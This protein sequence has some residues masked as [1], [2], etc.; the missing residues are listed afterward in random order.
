MTENDL[1]AY[2]DG[3]LD[4]GRRAEAEAWLAEHPEDAE[5][6]AAW[7]RFSQQLNDRFD[8]VL[9]EPAPLHL[10][11]AARGRPPVRPQVSWR[12]AASFAG[13]TL[14]AGALG[15]VIGYQA[16]GNAPVVVAAQPPSFAQRAMVAHAV[17]AP[18]QRRA[19]E[20]DAEHE[21]QLVRWL[22][23]RL[24][25]PLRVP[26]LQPLGYALEGGR[27]LPG[28]QGPVA[29]FMYRDGAGGRLTLYVSNEAPG[30]A[31]TVFPA[32]APFDP[33]FRFA[34]EGGVNSFYWV[35]GAWGYAISA[36]VDRAELARVSTEVYRQLTSP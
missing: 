29:Q 30:K 10:L 2:A 15:G 32:S 31:V 8:P 33:A 34:Q 3:Q 21:E 14:L 11:A 19:V 4:P 5:R 17:Y 35:D 9:R 25:S 1:H 26:Q 13:A 23:K 27:L 22:S 16:H 7:Q 24:G 28:N 12:L 20:V 18:D 36:G 6:V